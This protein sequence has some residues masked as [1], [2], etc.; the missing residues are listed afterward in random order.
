ME[1]QNEWVFFKDIEWNDPKFNQFNVDTRDFHVG[2]RKEDKYH[3]DWEIIKKYDKFFLTSEELV[4]EIER[5]YKESGGKGEWR[6]MDL[7]NKD[8]RVTGWG[9][10]YLRIWRTDKGFLVCNSY[11]K[12]I[13]K[14]VLKSPVNKKYLNHH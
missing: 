9:L 1:H 14:D 10:K 13:P 7:D 4:K 12:A 8:G 5:L 11:H 2:Y 3:P 6:M